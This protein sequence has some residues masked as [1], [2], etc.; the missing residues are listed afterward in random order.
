MNDDY[1][2]P[3]FRPRSEPPP[4]HQPPPSPPPVNPISRIEFERVFGGRVFA[5]MGGLA[6][7]LGVVFFLRS[8]VDSSWFTEE[9]RTLMGGIGSLLLLAFGVW[10]HERR[11]HLEVARAA[12]AAAIPGLY[13]TTVVATQAYDLISPLLGLEAAALVGA[14]G[15]FLA[16]RWSSILVGS[17]GMLGALAAPMMVGTATDSSSIAFVA[18]ALAA[19]VGVLL[20]QRWNWLALGAFAVSAPQL[21]AWVAESGYITFES[22]GDPSEP[23]LLVLAVLAG[24]WVL[25]AA[26]AFGYEL[27]SRGEEKL[28]VSSWL[29]LLSSSVLVV[30]AGCVVIDGDSASSFALDAWIFGFAGA[31]LLLGEIARRSGIHREV[32]S[33]L[34]GGG[35]GLA[36]FGVANAFDGPT[37][38]AAWAALAA[39]LAFLATRA[40]DSPS[41]ALS[42]AE[43]LWLVALGFLTLAIAHV[44]V[45]E[46]PLTAIAEGVEN[47]GESLA[48]IACCAGAAL[49]CNRFGRSVEPRTA[50]VVGFISGAAFVYLGSVAIID[51]IGV[52]A[53]GESGEVGQAWMSAFWAATGLGAV[54]WGMVRRAPSVR[55]GGLALLAIAIVKVWT[56]DLSELEDI[57]RAISFIGLGLLL[58]GGA[59]AYQRFKPEDDEEERG[60]DRPGERAPQASA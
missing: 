24:F 46:A 58:L 23:V 6:I 50:T 39:A 18:M 16:V 27:R 36:S 43:R 54:V 31:H 34:T 4:G 30:G 40:D 59:F 53:A 33:L 12:V 13:A 7:L 47:L 52:N 32:G 28:P 49:A 22:S 35:I 26:A 11:G 45:V 20:W 17:V 2:P 55:L 57:A 38:V 10:L 3:A 51:A 60:L 21:I 56:Y 14:V 42:N 15:V 9:V 48:A 19:S 37:V 5:W 25:Y 29:L 1:V 44:L 8:A 41:P